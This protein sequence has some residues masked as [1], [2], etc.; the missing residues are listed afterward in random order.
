MLLVDVNILVYAFRRDAPDHLAYRRYVES[1]AG[2]DEAFGAPPSVW[3]GFTRVATHPRIWHQPS[4]HDEVFSFADA[5]RSC[6]AYVHIAPGDRHFALFQKLCRE[7][8]AR[9]NLVTDAFL[10][11]I[12]IEHGADWISADSDFGRFRGLRWRHPLDA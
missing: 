2:G 9:G 10:A 1:L 6:A 8:S 7:T 12:A 5:I 3:N 11:A 4:S